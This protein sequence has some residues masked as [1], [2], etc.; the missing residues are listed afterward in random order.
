[1][2]LIEKTEMPWW[3]RNSASLLWDPRSLRFPACLLCRFHICQPPLPGE[4]SWKQKIPL[5]LSLLLVLFLSEEFLHLLLGNWPAGVKLELA[6]LEVF[7]LV[8][9]RLGVRVLTEKDRETSKTEECGWVQATK[10]MKNTH[11][12]SVAGSLPCRCNLCKVLT[13]CTLHKVNIQ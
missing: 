12:P 2:A 9:K 13:T 4:S 5:H 10:W 6:K 7:C 3:E 1:M 11:E 8:L